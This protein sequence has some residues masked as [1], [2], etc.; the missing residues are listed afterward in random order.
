MKME[1]ILTRVNTID[2]INTSQ[3]TF[4]KDC[5]QMS[6]CIYRSTEKS[7]VLIDEFGKGTDI[8]DGPGLLGGVINHFVDR[9]EASPIAIF[10]THMTEIFHSDMMGMDKRI[11][12]YHMKVILENPKA[13]KITFLYEFVAGIAESSCGL[14]CAR[15][16][17]VDM[18]IVEKVQYILDMIQEGKDIVSEFS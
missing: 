1:N 15:Q 12:F 8:N 7:L 11:Q 5:E 10:S 9:G 13:F 6:R 18:K 2:S 3:S 16:C 17:G 14:Y 4:L